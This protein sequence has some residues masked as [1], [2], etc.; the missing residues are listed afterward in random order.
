MN[1]ILVF[2]ENY[3]CNL[4]LVFFVFFTHGWIIF[5]IVVL[6]VPNELLEEA[7]ATTKSALEEMD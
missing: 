3:F 4:D 5:F 1:T 6:Q 2:F 7:K